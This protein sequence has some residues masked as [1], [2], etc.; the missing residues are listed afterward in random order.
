[1]RLIIPLLI[2]CRVGLSGLPLSAADAGGG[3]GLPLA[4]GALLRSRH[5]GRRGLPS[6]DPAAGPALP[7]AHR[8]LH[9]LSARALMVMAFFCTALVVIAAR[10]WP[11][12]PS[13]FRRAGQAWMGAPPDDR[14]RPRNLYFVWIYFS[15]L[16]TC[17]QFSEF[18]PREMRASQTYPIKVLVISRAKQCFSFFEFIGGDGNGLYARIF[19][20]SSVSFNGTL[21]NFTVFC[22]SRST[23]LPTKSGDTETSTPVYSSPPLS[24]PT[25]SSRPTAPW[26]KTVRPT[27]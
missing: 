9:P 8:H 17:C 1:M 16:D 27:W 23:P 19:F 4:H 6:L 5:P 18:R 12:G 20:S 24:M 21:S 25:R 2:A 26:S 14:R 3:G 11:G 10:C 15:A 7:G 13:G 22:I